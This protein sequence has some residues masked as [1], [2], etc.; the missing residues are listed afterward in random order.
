[1]IMKFYGEYSK[2][3]CVGS[4]GRSRMERFF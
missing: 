4:W 3:A 2:I 1:M